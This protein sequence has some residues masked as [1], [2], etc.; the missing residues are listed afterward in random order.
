MEELL[1]STGHNLKSFRKGEKVNAKLI[2][3]GE[4]SASFDIGGKSEGLLTDSNF[5]EARTLVDS[6]KVGDE[7]SALIMDPENRDGVALLSLR[8]AAQDD[9]WKK[10]EESHKDGKV[11]EVTVKAVNPH[12]LVVGLDTETAFV[13]SSQ[14]GEAV[15]KKGEGATGERIKVKI[16]DF[17]QNNNR[18][19]LSEKAVSEAGEIVKLEEAFE[20]IKDGDAFEG[21]VTTVTNFGAFVE[22]NIPVKKK[23]ISVEGLVHVSELSYTKVARPEDVVSVGDKVKVK[24]IGTDKNKLS[25]S[26]KQAGEDPWKE[27]ESK[28]KPDD[29]VKG[30]VVRV[31]DFGAFVELEPGIEG[32][33][34]MTKIP[35]GTSLKEG[36]EV[37]CYVEEVNKKDQ[38]LSLGIVV[39]TS[40][41][42]G[43]R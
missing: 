10:I 41:P 4:K 27:I 21:K 25:L 7:V 35:P 34:H 40:K 1:A 39:T 9:F 18:I 33:I 14:L 6:L 12:G 29:K 22:I 24:V 28:Y 38:R 42:V 36:E 30:K 5:A 32:L 20:N 13:P 2:R 11:F 19:V 16:I 17:D 43:Y 8:N 31:S 37:N 15:S 26:M 23:K 3:I